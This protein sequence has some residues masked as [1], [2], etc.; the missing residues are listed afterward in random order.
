ML[1]AELKAGIE[2]KGAIVILF[3]EAY[4][5]A[6]A[7]ATGSASVTF[8]HGIF[9]DKKS[10]KREIYYQPQLSFDGLKVTGNIK[11]KVGLSI[12]KG[13]YNRDINKE[14]VDYNFEK[15]IVKPFD[16]IKNIEKLTGINSK[17]YFK[18]E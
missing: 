15:I 8:G 18:N 7:K 9:F 12:K 2:V 1:K 4:V 17:L 5:S 16:V 6:E 11:A 3:T 10:D 13:I 14:L